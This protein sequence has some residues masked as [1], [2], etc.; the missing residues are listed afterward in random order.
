MT[1]SEGS[2]PLVV[3]GVDGSECARDALRFAVQE[4]QM[5]AARLQLVTAWSVP[6]NLYASGFSASVDASTFEAA[7]Q[8]TSA[9]ALQHAREAAPELQIEASTPEEHPVTALLAASEHADL[10]VVGSRGRG[11]F[12]RLVLGS[13][14]EQMAR[15]APCPV[16]I[17]RPVQAEGAS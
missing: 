15:N 17:V 5:R 1:P 13:V 9:E 6:T 3:V 16:T 7:A 14:G 8:A 2:P 12:A 10:L 11:G 4:A